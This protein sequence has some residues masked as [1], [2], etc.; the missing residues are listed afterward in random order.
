M[1][2]PQGTIDIER[3]IPSTDV[4]LIG[5]K[6]KVLIRGNLHPEIVQLLLQTMKEVAWRGRPLSSQR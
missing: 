3:V 5:T 4:Q 6:S 1:T 2:L